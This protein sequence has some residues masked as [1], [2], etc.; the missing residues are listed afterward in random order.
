MHVLT[1][2]ERRSLFVNANYDLTDNVRFST[3]LSYTKRQS[4][5]QIAGYPTQST[6]I[7]AAMAGA[8]YRTNPDGS[9]TFVSNGS[10][11]NPNGNN[12]LFDP[13]LVGEV[14]ANGR[15][16]IQTN[17]VDWRRRGWEVP[18]TTQSAVS[19]THLDVYKRQVRCSGFVW[20]SVFVEKSKT[21]TNWPKDTVLMNESD[22][23][24]CSQSL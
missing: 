22:T 6:A 23:I 20:K 15:E 21:T 3:D 9:R 13:E 7:G 4:F 5:R 19:Y 14:D 24:L 16:F 17:N 10:Y 1:P 2:I 8:V 11:F 18:R 12:D